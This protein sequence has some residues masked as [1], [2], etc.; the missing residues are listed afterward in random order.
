MVFC[1][2][3]SNPSSRLRY[4][5]PWG[6]ITLTFLPDMV[7]LADLVE[8]EENSLL[9]LSK[10]ATW[11]LRPLKA[12]ILPKATLKLKYDS[13]GAFIMRNSSQMHLNVAYH[14]YQRMDYLCWDFSLV[15]TVN[16]GPEFSVFFSK[17]ND[18]G[19]T[20]TIRDLRP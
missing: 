17:A 6:H 4:D 19:T 9:R 11:M 15:L 12:L 18:L 5:G 2:D 10:R 1:L 20:A 13:T 16:K 7:A 8:N 14:N 3:R